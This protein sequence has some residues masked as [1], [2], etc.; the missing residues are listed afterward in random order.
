MGER[1][2]DLDEWVRALSLDL[3]D[4]KFEEKVVGIDITVDDLSPA[5]TA[6]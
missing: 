3:K 2:V 6:L 4:V 5:L 1:A